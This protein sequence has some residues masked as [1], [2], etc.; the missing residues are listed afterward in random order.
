MLLS[1]LRLPTKK[2]AEYVK[3]MGHRFPK[4][5]SEYSDMKLTI[6]RERALEQQVGDLTIIGDGRS[7]GPRHYW[8]GEGESPLPLYLC[9]GQPTANPDDDGH[10]FMG[11]S[12][13]SSGGSNFLAAGHDGSHETNDIITIYEICEVEPSSDGSS[14]CTEQWEEENLADPWDQQ[15]L[16]LERSAGAADGTYLTQLYWAQWRANRSQCQRVVSPGK[17]WLG[18]ALLGQSLSTPVGETTRTHTSRVL[19]E[20][21]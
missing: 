16:E 10:Y 6:V 2:W 8:A 9:L 17:A 4:N 12:G 3:A 11:P 14:T 7:Q 21:V 20:A 5:E 15:K 1:L 19:P 13:E 18:S